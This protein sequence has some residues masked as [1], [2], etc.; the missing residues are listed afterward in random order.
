[1]P[2]AHG[3][4]EAYG[5]WADIR[6]KLWKG[7]DSTAGTTKFTVSYSEEQF[8]EMVRVVDVPDAEAK[9]R[10]AF[11]RRKTKEAYQISRR[12]TTLEL[13]FRV[14]C[15]HLV[16]SDSTIPTAVVLGRLTGC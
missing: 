9:L 14:V 4:G 16:C 8:I 13:R 3:A 5:R 11:P 10:L 7:L 1:M 12:K 6:T 2:R 15:K